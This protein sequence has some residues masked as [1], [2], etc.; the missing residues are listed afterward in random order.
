[1]N[2]DLQNKLYHF[3]ADPPKEVWSRIDDALDAEQSFPQRL[4]HYE[5][6]PPTQVWEAI[7][8]NLE[9]QAPAVKIVPITRYKKPIRYV[10]VAASIIAA[11]FLITRFSDDKNGAG[12]AIGGLEPVT[13]TNQSSILPS[14]KS[15][16][17]VTNSKQQDVVA[18]LSKDEGDP[19]TSQPRRTQTSIRP[20][21]L[22]S[23][24][25]FSQ[26]FLPGKAD[27]EALFDYSVM[28]SYM[29]YSDGD[30][31]AMRLPKKLFSFVNCQDG[32][33]TCKERVHQLQQ[34]LAANATTT[35]FGGILE[36]LR[37]LQ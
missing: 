7:A 8:A 1:M 10:A 16:V 29:V 3:E 20:Q 22:L 32:D 4:F 23:S 33:E 18:K 11:V 35:D 31:N 17:V 27:K 24:F 5:E 19:I 30:G 21:A 28:D 26:N 34:K 6:Q 14:G 13:T 15:P 9:E 25:S 2:S 36:I 37:Q 12:A